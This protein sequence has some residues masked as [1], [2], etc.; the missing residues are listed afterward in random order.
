MF[1]AL[2]DAKELVKWMPNE[3]KMDPRVGGDYE[4]K[5]HWAA[6]GLDTTLKGK[7]LELV[8]NERIS[9]TWD[10]RTAGGEDR[11]RR[12]VVT[13]LL[14]ELP[15]GKT[16]VTLVHSNVSKEFLQDAESGWTHY[17]SQLQKILPG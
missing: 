5:F 2:I 8:P 16:K 6:R 11:I 17:L 12:A 1:N 7:I 13:W 9:Y 3:A 4:F 15:G 14:E 10:S